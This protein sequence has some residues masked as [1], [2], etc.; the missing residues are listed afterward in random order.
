M[1]AICVHAEL[2]LPMKITLETSGGFANLSGIGGP[3]VIDTDRI[4]AYAAE[5][6]L[7]LIARVRFFDLPAV[8]ESPTSGAADFETHVITVQDGERTHSVEFSDPIR[9]EDLQ[10]L[11]STIQRTARS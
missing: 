4:D 10:R 1:I 8:A 7:S 3:L 6:I 2:R 5:K 9:N 11:T